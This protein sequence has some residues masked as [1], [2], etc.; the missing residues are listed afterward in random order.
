LPVSV[1]CRMTPSRSTFG[2]WRDGMVNNM[3]TLL[4]S[5][6]SNQR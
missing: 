1:S 4:S 6:P 3:T 5:P 2:I